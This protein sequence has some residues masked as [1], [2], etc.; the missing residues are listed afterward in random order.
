MSDSN[1]PGR[2]FEDFVV[3]SYVSLLEIAK[4]RFLFVNYNQAFDTTS[5]FV[6]WRHDIDVSP[7]RALA[8]A[9][10]EHERDLRSTYFVWLHSPMYHFFELE[11]VNILK[12]IVELGHDIGLHFD[13]GY[14]GYLDKSALERVIG[15][16][17]KLLEVVIGKK[18]D[19]LSYHDPGV[20]FPNYGQYSIDEL[21]AL[22]PHYFETS[23]CDRI[24][25]YGQY[26]RENV[27]YC[28]DSNGY[29]RFRKLKDVLQDPAVKNLQVLTHPEWWQKSPMP[30]RQ[31]ILRSI[32]GRAKH[33]IQNYDKTLRDHGREN[34]G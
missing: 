16:E 27:H 31:R 23:L 9:R 10:V 34:I 8:L 29:W 19:C 4:Q 26:F 18:I 14:Y 6:V 5:R 11:I 7:H 17:C 33:N 32:E 20:G 21:S 30:P 25:T 12:S 28:S 2:V 15:S 24:N 22:Y 3:T 13:T 1:Y